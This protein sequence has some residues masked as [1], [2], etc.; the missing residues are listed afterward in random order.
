MT[1]RSTL[2]EIVLRTG[3]DDG[4]GLT[5]KQQDINQLV[6]AMGH[7]ENEFVMSMRPF[8]EGYGKPIPLLAISECASV[9]LLL[10]RCEMFGH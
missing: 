7:Y 2:T 9:R 10:Y 1:Y 3:D 5:F 6:Q 8:E 4:G